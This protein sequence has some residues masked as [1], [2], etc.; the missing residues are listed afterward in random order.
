[1]RTDVLRV[2]SYYMHKWTGLEPLPSD[3]KPR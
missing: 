3:P 2:A 1:M